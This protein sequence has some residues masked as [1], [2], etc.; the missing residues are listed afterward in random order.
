MRIL[1]RETD[2]PF[3]EVLELFLWDQGYDLEIATDEL[4]PAAVPPDI[5][6]DAIISLR[7]PT[8]F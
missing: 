5:R 7:S 3:L 4:E 2:E 1:I 6:P 8:N